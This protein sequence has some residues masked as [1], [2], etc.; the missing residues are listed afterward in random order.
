MTHRTTGIHRILERPR[1][2]E[3]FQIL[4]GAANARRRL[5]SEFLRP[6]DGARILDIGCGTGSL[7][8]SL[9]PNVDYV[10]Y[11]LNP[12][13][14]EAA[15]KR[16]AG[17]AQFFCARVG[18]EGE[19]TGGEFDFVVAKSLLHHLSDGDAHHLLAT[20]RHTLRRGGVFFS[21]D[22]TRHEGQSLGTRLML[23]LDRGQ[24]I[25]TPD[26]Y[27]QL[28]AAHFPALEG[29]VVKDLLRIP[30]S[31]FIARACVG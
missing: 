14:I 22:P 29:V 18:G 9:P 11:D 2:Y 12:V 25:R 13:Y 4:L 28:I 3:R 10:G 7:L 27:R 15:R 24:S 6:F 5:V 16:Y 1:V 19:V 26:A 8:E 31:H 23:S 21:S 20:A 17:R 30:Y